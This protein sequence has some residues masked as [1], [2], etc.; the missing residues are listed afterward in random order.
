MEKTRLELFDLVWQKPMTHLSKEL[1]LSDVGLRKICVK[2]GIP[3]PARGYW[4]RLQHGRQ[5]PKPEIEFEKHN[6]LIQLPDESTAQSREQMS[7]MRKLSKKA[8]EEIAPVVRTVQQLKDPRCIKTYQ[9]IQERIRELEKKTGQR[10]DE[11]KLSSRSFPPKKVFDLALF[12]PRSQQIPI[13]ATIDNALRAV[14][15][16]D[17]VLERLAFMGIR[18]ELKDVND[19]RVTE[20]RA[21]KGEQS[22]EFRFWEPT[23]RSART[24]AITSLERLFELYSFGGDTIMLPR[25]ILTVQLDGRFGTTVIQDKVSVKLEQQIDV[26][27]EKIDHKLDAKAKAHL[28]H[29]AWEKEYERKREI[30]IHNQR[31]TADRARQLQVAIKESKDFEKLIRLKRYLKQL[32]I[33]IEKLPED[34]KAFGQAWMRMIRVERKE[35]NPIATRLAAF[36]D[37][38]SDDETVGKEYWGLDYLDEDADPEFEEVFSDELETW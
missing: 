26:I 6:P 35:L 27:V 17:V 3:L 12:R 34:Q 2:F 29:L 14:C 37:L 16:A 19:A 9:A 31:V 24:N 1:G 21:I 32:S 13:T 8:A 38:A 11:Y 23:T 28:E 10:Y 20:M 4:S 30:R 25:H 18:V 22:L 33:A 5:D 7:L 36:R 15:I